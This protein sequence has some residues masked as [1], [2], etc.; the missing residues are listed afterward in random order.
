M[1][2]NE[3][4]WLEPAD[5]RSAE[6]LEPEA[7]EAA[8]ALLRFPLLTAEHDRELLHH[9]VHHHEQLA[10]WFAHTVGWRMTAHPHDGF[11]RLFKRRIQP[12]GDRTKLQSRTRPASKLVLTIALLVC[13]QLWRRPE[14]GFTELQREITAVCATGADQGDLPRF[15]PV[16]AVG[17]QHHKS[18]SYRLALVEAL[19]L[20]EE[21]HVIACSDPLDIAAQDRTADMGITARRER[22]N[23]LLASSS[24]SLLPIDYDDPDTHVALLCA[25]QAELPEHASAQQ[26]A[27][28][29]R[30][31]AM[32]LVLDEPAFPVDESSEDTGALTSP[33]GRRY[34]VEAAEQLGLVCVTGERWWLVADP[35][36][37]ACV[38]EFPLGRTLEHQAALIVL[39]EL[40]E[41]PDAQAPFTAED[42]ELWLAR[43]RQTAPWW[44][45]ARCEKPGGTKRLARLAAGY[46]AE[47]AL[48]TYPMHDVWEPTGA[49]AFWHVDIIINQDAT[50]NCAPDTENQD[51]NSD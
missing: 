14:I 15:H 46:L 28:R 9:A 20:L 6:H 38:S 48:L 39:R 21:W 37:A 18:N 30:H 10:R 17:N 13:E 16:D 27:E 12:P 5:P 34:A 51:E 40:N 36:G 2:E 42:A 22:L 19:Q 33:R 35:N 8:E 31:L 50:S 4:W 25:D 49:A 29:R 26:R 43:W 3:P 11:V 44:A 41:R 23:A 32:R 47:Y 24:P 7:A 45:A 1:N